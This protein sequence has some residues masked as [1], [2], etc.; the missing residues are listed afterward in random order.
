M[1][2]IGVCG[3]GDQ[4]GCA[5]Q[6]ACGPLGPCNVGGCSGLNDPYGGPGVCM[7]SYRGCN[8]KSVCKPTDCN[9][10]ECQGFNNQTDN[11]QNA[12]G[13]CTAGDLINCQCNSVCPR[14]MLSCND[15]PSHCTG[16]NTNIGN[17]ICTA[18]DYKG[19]ECQSTC[20]NTS[21]Q[22]SDPNCSGQNG[23]CQIGDQWGCTCVGNSAPLQTATQRMDCSNP[24]PEDGDGLCTCSVNEKSVGTYT[25]VGGNCPTEIPTGVSIPLTPPSPTPPPPPPTTAL[26]CSN[27]SPE[28]GDGLCTCSVGTSTI[29]TYTP[30]GGNCPTTRPSS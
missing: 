11:G 13:L 17:G 30:Q 7:E 29:G 26:E 15:G 4:H 28:D 25:P 3:S 24:S 10:N 23:K 19:C 18:G 21:L 12:P 16:L 8:C 1:N 14:E 5:C 9:A 27:P 22:C 2:S 20:S 6:S